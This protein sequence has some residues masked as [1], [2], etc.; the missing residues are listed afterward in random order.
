MGQCKTPMGLSTDTV[1]IWRKI[2]NTFSD[3]LNWVLT[4]LIIKDYPP[5]E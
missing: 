2:Y 1:M 3:A 5:K 4:S